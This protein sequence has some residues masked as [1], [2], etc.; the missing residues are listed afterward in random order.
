MGN[1]IRFID[2]S[3]TEIFSIKDKEK[4][5]IDYEDGN[6]A[7]RVCRYI[8]D[9][10]I[11][12][13]DKAY[14]TAAFLSEIAH[15]SRTVAP[16]GVTS[17]T[18]DLGLSFYTIE[19]ASGSGFEGCAHYHSDL[20]GAK[21]RFKQLIAYTHDTPF[22]D[23]GPVLGTAMRR[24]STMADIGD[25]DV[26]HYRNGE[27]QLLT[28]SFISP[29]FNGSQE[30]KDALRELVPQFGIST[31]RVYASAKKSVE[32]KLKQFL[33]YNGNF[34]TVINTGEIYLGEELSAIAGKK[35]LFSRETEFKRISLQ[36]I[37]RA[38]RNYGA[39][40]VAEFN[41]GCAEDFPDY[42]VDDGSG[43]IM[44]AAARRAGIPCLDETQL[45]EMVT[46]VIE[47]I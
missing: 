43:N 26:L 9:N 7:V 15:Y 13:D 30:L 6:S 20:A 36:D 28:D 34:D 19:N 2:K 16:L 11:E 27:C 31:I 39:I 40:P 5:V 32:M 1:R 24:G 4:I 29:L 17:G 41:P 33:K 37:I 23:V 38:L 21:A 3:G 25:L 35:F 14:S 22:E 42:A 45:E 44:I 47:A 46:R 12:V 10:N 18:E 8:D